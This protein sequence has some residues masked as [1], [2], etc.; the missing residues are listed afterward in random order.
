MRFARTALGGG[1]V[2]NGT[3]KARAA[4]VAQANGDTKKPALFWIILA[5]AVF[6]YLGLITNFDFDV[7]AGEPF[8]R[9]FNQM[10]QRLLSGRFDIDLDVVRGEGFLHNGQLVS[11]FGVF[12][13]LLRLP[14]AAF[15]DLDTV[16]LSRISC[17]LGL[18]V[19][20]FAQLQMLWTAHE[21]LDRRHRRLWLLGTF[22]AALLL[23]GPQLTLTFSA[24]VYNEPI[25]W[26]AA[27]AMLFFCVVLDEL[28]NPTY[29]A[30]KNYLL[31]ALVGIAFLCRPTTGFGLLV[32]FGVVVAHFEWRLRRVRKLVPRPSD[33]GTSSALISAVILLAFGI[34]AAWINFSRFG[35]IFTFHNPRAN[36][37]VMSDPRRMKVAAEHGIFEFVR[38]A[39]NFAYYFLGFPVERL[40]PNLWHT[41]YDDMGWPRS[42][43][44]IK[45]T[46]L[47][48]A[49]ALGA[50][51]LMGRVRENS[52]WIPV[53]GAALGGATI[54][55]FML[56]LP[57]MNYRYQM[58]LQPFLSL[59]AILGYIPVSRFVSSHSANRT[60]LACVTLVAAN[61]AISH[62]DL[63]HA[64]LVNFSGDDPSR[65][66]VYEMTYPVSTL[67]PPV[68]GA[69]FMSASDF[70][71][72]PLA[73][74]YRAAIAKARDAGAR[75][76]GAPNN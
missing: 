8:W 25:I 73:A 33:I 28:Q 7:F 60:A 49:A 41:N 16:S 75:P 61:V 36:L 53:A 42:A 55:L 65:A 30:D 56:G 69:G 54:V 63:L 68:R 5:A 67:F 62:Y 51:E 26:A 70:E 27:C 46:V 47:I 34:F 58:D 57:M 39:P 74:S 14:F 50:K 1:G 37:I 3:L 20:A 19:C 59:L 11:Y 13:A 43:L 76:P 40:M 6:W 29:S 17:W 21:M 2:R 24:Y 48:F 9:V 4:P 10:L 44:L 72:S 64:K 38:L 12:P 52:T 71:R 31:A 23:T 32:A 45:E 22:A 66:R 18:C 35:N 15:V